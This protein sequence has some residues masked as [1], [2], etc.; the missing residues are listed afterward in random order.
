MKKLT[1]MD[2][3]EI[4]SYVARCQKRQEKFQPGSRNHQKESRRIRNAARQMK[5]LQKRTI[6]EEA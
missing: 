2:T 1:E 4:M 5:K 6:P 3:Q